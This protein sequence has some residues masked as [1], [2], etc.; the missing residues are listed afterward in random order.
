MPLEIGAS[1]PDIILKDKDGKDFHLSNFVGK[2]HF[3]IYFYPKNFTPGCNTEAC[4]FR[5]N[6]KLFKN[7]GAEIIGISTDT[8]GSHLKFADKY[9]LPFILL[10]DK[11]KVARKAF[12]VKGA[13][14]GLIP[15]RETFIF[16]KSG[17][18]IFKY[19]SINASAH[20]L[21]AVK[22]LKDLQDEE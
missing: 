20:V 2:K 15:G 18:L 4:D 1:V 22:K 3:V 7:L 21:V 12:D 11:S 9:Q 6:Y 8:C 14:F 13:M 19:N 16:N 10:S 5:D 17:E